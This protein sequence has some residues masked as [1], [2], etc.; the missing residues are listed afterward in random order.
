MF[1]TH[2]PLHSTLDAHRRSEHPIGHRARTRAH[3]LAPKARERIS[4]DRAAAVHL[5]PR[6]RGA[7]GAPAH[8]A[9][10]LLAR[11]RGIASKHAARTFVRM[12]AMLCI[13]VGGSGH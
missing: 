4:R 2:D 6:A 1:G 9:R 5:Q 13:A 8:A 10:S 11:A 3:P 12:R 7:S